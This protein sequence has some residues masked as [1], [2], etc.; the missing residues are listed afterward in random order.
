MASK[1]FKAEYA[2][3]DRY[4]K[5]YLTKY[6]KEPSINKYKE[7]WAITSLLED[8]G[9]DTVFEC[10]DYYFRTSKVDHPLT[11]FFFNFEQLNG[12]MVSQKSDEQLRR[13]RRE[14]TQMI[15]K[16]YLDGI[17]G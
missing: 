1:S 6:G 4:K 8:Y 5:L 10:L 11:W 12:S 13:L 7:K 2:F 3:I 14:K 9:H 17:Q 16:E 15:V